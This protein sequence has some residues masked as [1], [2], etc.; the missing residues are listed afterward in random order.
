MQNR[1]VVLT[2]RAG[3]IPRPEHFELTT[4][5]VPGTPAG[6]LLIRNHYLSVD[7]AM[8]G[9]I[10]D[11]KGYLAPVPIGG[12]MRSLAVGEVIGSDSP[13]YREGD[14]VTGWF[15]WQE[16]AAVETD[17]VIRKVHQ[18]EGPLT[19][20]LGVLGLNGITAYLAF[21]GIGKPE[22]GETVL[23]STAA[24]A[25]GS[26][27]GQIARLK[28][29]RTV[30]LTGSDDKVS[31]CTEEF[32]Y[33]AALNYKTCGDLSAAVA[34]A[35]PDGIDIFFDN[36]AGPIADSVFGAMNLFG[37]II[38]CGTA[39]IANWEPLPEGPRR[40]RFFITK[41]LLQQGF[42]VF[43]HFDKW[44]DTIDRLSAWLKSGELRYR[45][46]IRDGLGEAPQALLDLY[47]G[48]NRGKTLI[49][50]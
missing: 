14:F 38:Q 43:D 32:G 13:D 20:S 46:D 9:W 44:P 8:R 17:K 41:R 42:V 39:S 28:G 24:G 37:R 11:T 2:E 19:A 30:G 7:P 5:E 21:T 22:P 23:V 1:Q 10:N 3:G 45:E 34:A 25:V 15:G 29:C 31:Q 49:R 27:V 6:G 35:C 47:E 4:A 36:T 48:T 18:S 26:I 33:D 40:E 16:I 12:V 50:V